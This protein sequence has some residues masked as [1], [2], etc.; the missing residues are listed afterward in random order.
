M[1]LPPDAHNQAEVVI[2]YLT[3][4][5]DQKDGGMTHLQFW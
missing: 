5:K 1:L 3:H 4:H 2:S